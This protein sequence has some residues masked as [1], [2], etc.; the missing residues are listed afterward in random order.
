MITGW[1]SFP[2]QLDLG[3]LCHL[4]LLSFIYSFIPNV[5]TSQVQSLLH[6]ESALEGVRWLWAFICLCRSQAC[7]LVEN[8]LTV[9]SAWNCPSL[10]LPTETLCVRRHVTFKSHLSCTASPRVVGKG[11]EGWANRLRGGCLSVLPQPH[12]VRLVQSLSRVRLF[13][14]SW[15]AACQ[16]SPSFTISQSLLKLMSIESVMPS[17]HLMLC[18]PLLLQ[19]SIFSSI[20]V[21]PN[22]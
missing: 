10:W 13:A 16:A 3:I 15:T 1:S 14:T 5:T 8:M 18:H 20:R 6:Q 11:W 22:E 19:P 7:G 21:F 9:G 4:F 2:N 12:V 17:D